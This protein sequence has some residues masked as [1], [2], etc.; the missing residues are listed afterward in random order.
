VSDAEVRG[1]SLLDV[2]WKDYRGWAAAARAHQGE[3][4]QQAIL[5]LVITCSAALFGALASIHWPDEGFILAASSLAAILVAIGTVLGRHI[6]DVNAQQ[7]WLQARATAEAIQSECYRYAA[8]C[9]EYSNRDAALRFEDRIETL[10]AAATSKG[11]FADAQARA[12]ARPGPTIGMS[13]DWYRTHRLIDQRDWYR[14][15]S[16]EHAATA[17]LL[18]RIGLALGSV[19]AV[20]GVISAAHLVSWVA[21]FVAMITTV[22]TSVAAYGA[23]GRQVYL[24]ASY[25]A[26][27]S[28][29]DRLLAL[30][31]EGDLSDERLV[32]AA[33]DLLSSEHRAWA[34][35]VAQQEPRAKRGAS[36]RRRPRA[37]TSR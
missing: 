21:P 1:S 33:E 20:L 34:D 26:M 13:P 10:S 28:Q 25:S 29:I 24:A 17:R 5:V 23:L 16:G 7:K 32:E 6:L 4:R 14:G 37:P 2:A 27:V 19:A 8:R 36:G 9:G 31:N 11:L 22:T 18:R 12:A 30:N 35:R 3:Y 15:R